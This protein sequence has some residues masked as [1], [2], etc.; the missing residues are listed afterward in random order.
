MKIFSPI[1]LAAFCALA[2]TPTFSQATFT[3]LGGTGTRPWSMS[4]DG[5]WITGWNFSGQFRWSSSTGFENFTAAFNG[6][7][8]IAIGGLPVA[9]TLDNGG[10]EEAGYWTPTGVTYFGGI[11]GQ[12]GNSISSSYGCSDDGRQRRPWDKNSTNQLQRL[13]R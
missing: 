10:N 2:A 8:D 5:Q 6:F 13:W 1:R 4:P 11:G 12:S 7:P 9:A 3:T